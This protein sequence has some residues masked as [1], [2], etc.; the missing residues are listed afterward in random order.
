MKWNK[1]YRMIK[2]KVMDYIFN[3]LIQFLKRRNISTYLLQ[4]WMTTLQFITRIIYK[5]S[6]SILKYKL[7]I[8]NIFHVW[9]NICT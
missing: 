4:Y 1:H 5:E 6:I 2:R 7:K 8:S 9:T 3:T